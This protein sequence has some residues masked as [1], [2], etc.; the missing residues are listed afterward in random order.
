MTDSWA[1]RAA[2]YLRRRGLSGATAMADGRIS[3][4]PGVRAVAMDVDMNY[5]DMEY[6]NYVDMQMHM[7]AMARTMPYTVL[8]PR[9]GFPASAGY[10][11]LSVGGFARLLGAPDDG[12]ATPQELAAVL[13]T[14]IAVV[15]NHDE[16]NIVPPR[17]LVAGVDPVGVVATLAALYCGVARATL[18]VAVRDALM[19]GLGLD[20]ALRGAA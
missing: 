19:Q 13:A 9:P 2:A 11:T 6:M 1:V 12:K 17:D 4:L 10:V 15:M 18:P 16:G 20:A 8:Q 14:S 7:S 3:G 5:V